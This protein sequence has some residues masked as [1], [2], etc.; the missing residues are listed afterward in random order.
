[1]NL[2]ALHRVSLAIVL[3]AATVIPA[4]AQRREKEENPKKQRKEWAREEEQLIDDIQSRAVKEA[5]QEARRLEKEG[6]MVFPGSLPLEKQLQNTWMRQY[7]ENPDGSPKYLY[8][9]GN[10]VGKTQTAAEMQA[11]EAAKLQLA[12]QISNDVLQIIEAKIANDQIDRESGNSLSKFV[13]GSKNYI[14]QNLSY[15]KPF[16]KVYRNVGKSDMEVVVKVF[17]SAEEA[18]EAVEKALQ[19]K[20]RAE[21]E[22]EADRLVDEINRLFNKSSR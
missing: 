20:A 16:F 4:Q 22:T 15:I 21:L 3:A 1:M 11:M 8:S 10:G 5:R 7:Q 13:A 17:Y 19:Q 14:A 6:F 18:M 9:D 12:G 2:R